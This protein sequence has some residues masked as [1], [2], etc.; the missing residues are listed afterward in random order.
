MST[1]KEKGVS[2]DIDGAPYTLI[3]NLNALDAVL[4]EYGTVNEFHRIMSSGKVIEVMQVVTFLLSVMVNDDIEAQNE[5]LPREKWIP[6]FT[7]NG[8]TRHITP[9]NYPVYQTAVYEA[10]ANGNP[11]MSQEDLDKAMEEL[12]NAQA[13]QE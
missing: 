12:K 3:F 8:I 1:L 4:E 2:V 13:K 10:V 5:R 9:K 7:Q 6:L 11:E